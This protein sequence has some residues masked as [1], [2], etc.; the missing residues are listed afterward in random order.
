[1]DAQFGGIIYLQDLDGPH[2]QQ[3]KRMV[4]PGKLTR[5]EPAR[6]VVLA[7]VKGN[8]VLASTAERRQEQFAASFWKEAAEGGSETHRYMRTKDSAWGIVDTIL[9]SRKNTVELRLIQEDLTR[10]YK[11]MSSNKSATKS[12][13]KQWM[14]SFFSIFFGPKVGRGRVSSFESSATVNVERIPSRSVRIL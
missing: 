12:A 2:I 1:M 9:P 8:D 10:I 7:T 5:P 6:R 11:M 4:Y 3:K 13:P 14:C